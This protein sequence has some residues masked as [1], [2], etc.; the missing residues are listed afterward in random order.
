MDLTTLVLT[1]NYFLFERDFYLQV[2]GTAMGTPIP[3]NYA[4]LFM[5]KFEQDHVYNNNP[6]QSNIKVWMRYIDDCFMIWSGSEQEL[7]SFVSFINSKI[8]SIKFTME[9]SCDS[10]HFWDVKVRK[11]NESLHTT[12]FRKPTDKNTIL[13]IDSYHPAPLKRSLPISQLHRLKRNCSNEHEFEEQAKLLFQLFHSK[14]YP[15][16]WLNNALDKLNKLNRHDLLKIN[17]PNK[18]QGNCFS[19]LFIDIQ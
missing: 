15:Q 11:I 9:K 19:K 2:Q 6:F 12:V 4:N 14:G 13:S 3:P 18:K 8:P 7:D 10:I 5:G 1:K 17:I 16:S